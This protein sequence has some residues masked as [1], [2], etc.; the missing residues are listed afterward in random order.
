MASF[1][2]AA[3]PKANQF[4]GATVAH[5]ITQRISDLQQFIEEKKENINIKDKNIQDDINGLLLVM[6]NLEEISDNKETLMLDLDE[7][8]QL[9]KTLMNEKHEQKKDSDL[10]KINKLQEE[11]KNLLLIAKTVDKDISGPVKQE[12]D[13]TKEKIKKFEE[14]LKEYM[15]GLKKENFYVYKTGIEDSTKRIEEVNKQIAEFEQKLS[16]FEYYSRMF[17]FPDEVQGCQ[18]NLETIKSEVSAVTVLWEHIKKCEGRFGDYKKY[19]W[20][21]VNPDE[22]EDEINKLMKFLKEMRG[23][24]KRSNVFMGI[25]DDLKKWKTF[26]PLLNDLKDPSMST[27]DGRHWKEVKAVVKQDFAI[28]DEMELEVIWNLKM[29]DYKD[30]IE[31]IAEQAKQELKME[32]GIDKVVEFWKDVQFELMKHK[33]TQIYTLKMLDEQ[34]ETLEEHQLQ[35]NNM[36]LSK[37][38]KFFEK[39]V[40]KWKQ[41]LGAVYDV[42]QLLSEVQKTWSFLEN[43]FIQ[44]EE[45]KKELPNESQQFIGI[46]RNMKEIMASGSEIKNIL[47]FCTIAGMLKRLEAIQSDLKVCEKALNEFLESKRKAF[48]RFYFVSVNDLLDILSNGNSPEKINRHMSKIFQAIDNLVLQAVDGAR[49]KASRMITCVG[50]EEVDITNPLQLNGKVEVYLQDIIDCMQSTLRAIATASFKN[51]GT[52]ERKTWIEM[53]PAQI[54]LLVNNIVWSA[55]IEECFQKIGNGDMNALKDFLKTSIELLTDL[56]RMVRG[57]LK[58]PLR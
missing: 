9:V 16:D 15:I 38:V 19:K 58:K 6:E 34:F 3:N 25:N 55:D 39:E 48:P 56:I 14:Q 53:D 12:S 20:A 31:E 30:R 45:V 49:P 32:K 40:E 37:H 4:T 7:N 23:I 2:E 1:S 22:M 28:G 35:I 29:F 27:S 47:N 8:E 36:L 24:D 33:D 43:L 41:D 13:R 5:H 42:V 44:S 10:R 11:W 54:T 17:K 57:D 26:I 50:S 46:D 51:K 52:M 21:E 18:K